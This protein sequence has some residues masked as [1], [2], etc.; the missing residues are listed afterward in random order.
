MKQETAYNLTGILR[1]TGEIN[2]FEIIESKKP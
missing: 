1:N 2:R